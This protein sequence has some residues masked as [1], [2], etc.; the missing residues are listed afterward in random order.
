MPR[1]ADILGAA[2]KAQPRAPAKAFPR[3]ID[4]QSAKTTGLRR[5]VTALVRMME[6]ASRTRCGLGT[7]CRSA[8][9]RRAGVS[10]DAEAKW[11]VEGQEARPA[12]PGEQRARQSSLQSAAPSPWQG[13][14][15]PRWA[16]PVTRASGA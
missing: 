13:A 1:G 12:G 11:P 10:E 7:R 5:Q 14:A 2:M 8:A 16:R 6:S 3:W 4:K 9:V 15:A